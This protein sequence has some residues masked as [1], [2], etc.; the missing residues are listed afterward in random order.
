MKNWMILSFVLV[1]LFIITVVTFSLLFALLA[2]VWMLV[3]VAM[4][5]ASAE[6]FLED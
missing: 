4:G 3:G 1:S 5:Q 6:E 2:L